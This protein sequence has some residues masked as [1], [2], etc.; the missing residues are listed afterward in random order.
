MGMIVQD[1]EEEKRAVLGFIDGINAKNSVLNI[2]VVL[3]L[4][5]NFA[6]LYCYEG[7]LKGNFYLSDET[8]AGLIDYVKR[9]FPEG[10]KRLLID[11]YGGEPLLSIDKI[12]SISQALK[13]IS[14]ERGASYEFTLITNGSLF[15][16]KVVEKLVPLGLKSVQITLDGPAEN[17]NKYRPFKTGAPSFDTIVRNIKETCDLVKVTIGGNYE[18]DNYGK[19]VQLLDY[20][21]AVGLTADKLAAVK[22]SPVMK[23]SETGVSATHYKQGC[24][25]I[26]DPWLVEAEALLRQEI[27]KRGYHTPRV[28][29]LTCIIEIRDSFVMNFDGTFY[30]CP[31]FIGRKEFA[32]G[33]LHAGIKDYTSSYRPGIWK[34]QEC[35]ECE[36]LPLCFGGCR[37]MTFIREGVVETDCKKPYLDRALERLVKQEIK[38]G[39]K[40]GNNSAKARQ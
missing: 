31:A 32:V 25:S 1:R 19:F 4:D 37:Y 2:T 33:D 18:R 22:F 10:K 24:M 16:R 3:N 29:P 23:S 13:S 9:N 11:F 26:N 12:V 35:A 34:R 6:C 14:E 15:R 27:L 17:H 40:T 20:L 5:C 30:K 21:Q 36:Y 7:N 38:Y 39:L 28:R 8:E